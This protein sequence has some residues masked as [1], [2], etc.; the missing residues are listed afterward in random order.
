MKLLLTFAF[1]LLPLAFCLAQDAAPAPAPAVDTSNAALAWLL[2]LALANPKLAI[3]FTVMGA[4]RSIFKIVFA[5]VHRGD[6]TDFDH[7]IA[8]WLDSNPVAR[9]V[10]WLL[11]LVA[12]IKVAHPQ[13]DPLLAPASPVSGGRAF[14]L[15][16]PF[17]LAG[18]LASGV[19][20]AAFKARWDGL[21]PTTQTA[22]ENAAKGAAKIAL[23]IGLGELGD[24]VHEL[25]PYTQRL[26]PLFETT[27][28]QATTD[29][30]AIGNALAAHVQAVV[31]PEHQATVRA[32]LKDAL[33][34]KSV[35]AGAVPAAQ[36]HSQKFN[37]ALAA[38][39]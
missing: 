27:F 11:D 29:P 19:G 14:S 21:A 1:C 38:R 37:A 24:R 9:T 3:L 17:A 33:A 32:A 31:P 39:L 20:C 36:T 5:V 18:L 4:L 34:D 30:Q 6:A 35:G 13:A 22:L 2:Q 12:S 26:A 8:A 25:K 23:S 16:L 28:A 7:R 10:A 15:L